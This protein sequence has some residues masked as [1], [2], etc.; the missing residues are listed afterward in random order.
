MGKFISLYGLE[1]VLDSMGND[2]KDII[3][4][5]GDSGNFLE[6]PKS[7]SK[8]K[9][10]RQI[11]LQ[12]NAL[13]KFPMAICDVKSLQ[14]LGLSNNPKLTSLPECLG[15]LPDLEVIN[16]KDSSITEIPNSI[17]EKFYMVG[18]QM[19]QIEDAF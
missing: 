19:Y 8:F 15:N 10:L 9:N 17:K 2:L 12:N 14:F 13:D 1:E 4:S 18:P 5:V 3:I 7:I 16:F 6:I 11:N